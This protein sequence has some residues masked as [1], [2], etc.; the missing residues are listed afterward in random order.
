[1]TQLV[2]RSR[3]VEEGP[4]DALLNPRMYGLELNEALLAA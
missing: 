4:L 2:F 1:M 3:E